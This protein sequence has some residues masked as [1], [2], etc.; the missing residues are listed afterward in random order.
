MAGLAQDAAHFFKFLFIL[1]LY[2]LA[3]TLFVS[4]VPPHGCTIAARLTLCGLEL[5]PRMPVPQRRHCDPPVRVDCAIPDDVCRLLR[6][7]GRHP[8]GAAM[9]AVDLP[10]QVHA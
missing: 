10:A 5:P 4:A 2:T 7:L 8:A 3:M 6:A 1:V 9:A